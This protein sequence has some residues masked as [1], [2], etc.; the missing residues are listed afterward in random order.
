MY[1]VQKC[2]MKQIAQF[3]RKQQ[4]CRA[5]TNQE[6][7][8]CLAV[9]GNWKNGGGVDSTDID[10]E[11]NTV[12]LQACAD[13]TRTGWLSNWNHAGQLDKS[14]GPQRSEFSFRT[15]F[16]SLIQFIKLF[17]YSG[18]NATIN[19]LSSWKC[20]SQWPRG[21]RRRSTAARLL[22]SWVRIPL[23]AWMFVCCECCVLSGRGLCDGLII[24]SEESYRLWRVVVCDHETSQA[25]R[26]KPARG[27]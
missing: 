24:R 4:Q 17:P 25:R 3:H 23:R 20:R 18:A 9:V 19:S 12:T 16:A 11:R 27:L 8:L 14:Q 6:D 21:L 15:L 10:T 22:W 7:V 13:P 5:S 2:I 26:L 1:I